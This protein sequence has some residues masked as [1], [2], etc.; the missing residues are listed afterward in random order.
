MGVEYSVDIQNQLKEQVQNAKLHRPTRVGRYE[1]GTELAYEVK[2]V[3]DGN[4]G[5]VRL[6]VEK[7]VGGGFAGQVYRVTVVDIV[8]DKTDSR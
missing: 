8:C 5:R 6:A 4:E 7:F 1:V 2:G 3:T